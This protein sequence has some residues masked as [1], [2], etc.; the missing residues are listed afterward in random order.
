MPSPGEELLR[1]LQLQAEAAARDFVQCSQDPSIYD[2]AALSRDCTDQ[3]TPPRRRSGVQDYV[4]C[5]AGV[6]GD[7][8]A[9]TGQRLVGRRSS[10]LCIALMMAGGFSP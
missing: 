4:G 8:V 10:F 9:I 2:R 6:R 1:R 7:A 5:E 3:T